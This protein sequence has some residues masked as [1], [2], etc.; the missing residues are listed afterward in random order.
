MT[1]SI[2]MDCLTIKQCVDLTKDEDRRAQIEQIQNEL[3]NY[4]RTEL[5]KQL[6][7]NIFWNRAAFELQEKTIN[8]LLELEMVWKSEI[9]DIELKERLSEILSS[10]HSQNQFPR[11]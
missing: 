9:N 7:Q 2:M 6:A 4:D 10:L 11:P 8:T 3:Q 1:Q 5:I